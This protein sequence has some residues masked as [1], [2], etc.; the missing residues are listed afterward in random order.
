MGAWALGGLGVEE[1][2]SRLAK[3]TRERED[4]VT[5]G[6]LQRI[7]RR[8]FLSIGIGKIFRARGD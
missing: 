5:H 6:D 8:I 2:V 7:Q 1:R 3:R 4:G